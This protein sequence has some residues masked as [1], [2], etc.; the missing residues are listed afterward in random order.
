[1]PTNGR[2]QEVH[3][4]NIPPIH[5]TK[6]PPRAADPSGGTRDLSIEIASNALEGSLDVFQRIT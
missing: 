4:V 5:A 6:W 1:M 3:P 2:L